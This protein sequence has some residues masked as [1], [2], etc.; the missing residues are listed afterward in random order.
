MQGPAKHSATA[1]LIVLTTLMLASA[2]L[3]PRVPRT[4]TAPIGA[5]RIDLN[6]ASAAEL[7]ALPRI[8]PALARRIV[9][10]RERHGPFRTIEELDHVSGIG[11]RTLELLRP[12]AKVDQPSP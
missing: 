8:G 7:E 4:Q 12:H 1:A 2:L 3:M 9:E 5:S 6:R 10:Y 11:P